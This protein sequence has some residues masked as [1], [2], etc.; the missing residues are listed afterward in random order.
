ML[1]LSYYWPVKTCSFVFL[2]S[3]VMIVP[4]GPGSNVARYSLKVCT[5]RAMLLWTLGARVLPSWASTN[6]NALALW[7]L[8]RGHYLAREPLFI[9]IG[10]G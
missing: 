8:Q 2:T 4:S 9:C 3:G 7:A 1:D 6:T 5:S 10:S